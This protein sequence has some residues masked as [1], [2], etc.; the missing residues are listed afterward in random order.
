MTTAEGIAAF[1][2]NE[3]HRGEGWQS[4]TAEPRESSTVVSPHDQVRVF[5]NDALVN[6][7][8]AGNGEFQG[9]AHDAGSMAVKEFYDGD[10]VVGHAV[11]YQAENNTMPESTVYYCVGPQRRCLTEGPAFSLDEPAFGRGLEIGCGGCHG[12]LVF[13]TMP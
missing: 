3:N 10:N 2:A 1:L 4:E 8:R 11:I 6:S 13:T 12:G 9:T 7:Q 5:F